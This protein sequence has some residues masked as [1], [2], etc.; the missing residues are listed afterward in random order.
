M[1]AP[2]VQAPASN[3]SRAAATSVNTADGGERVAHETLPQAS[4]DEAFN[5]VLRLCRHAQE[6]T[7]LNAH[8]QAARVPGRDNDYCVDLA[9]Q[10]RG[11][12]HGL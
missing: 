11:Y 7:H 1:P 12:L 5:G 4:Q 6:I 10:V 8:M 2:T 3:S 9:H